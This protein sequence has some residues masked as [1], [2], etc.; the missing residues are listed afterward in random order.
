MAR[1]RFSLRPSGP[2]QSPPSPSL[3]WR[4][5]LTHSEDQQGCQDQAGGGPSSCCRPESKV[6]TS[7]SRAQGLRAPQLH[8]AE[9]GLWLG[10]LLPVFLFLLQTPLLGAL[11]T[12]V[13]GLRESWGQSLLWGA[14]W[15]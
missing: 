15:A 12:P 14:W 4:M 2:Q 10:P 7:W 11:H 8:V 5:A 9:V 1:W 6:L 3:V 13:D